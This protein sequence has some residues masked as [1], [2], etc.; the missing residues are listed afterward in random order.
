MQ[1]TSHPCK[2]EF[3]YHPSVRP[4]PIPC[5]PSHHPPL[6]SHVLLPK[7]ERPLL[8]P[9]F[10]CPLGSSHIGHR[11]PPNFVSLQNC[12]PPLE[13][14]TW[15]EL[16]HWSSPPMEEGSTALMTGAVV[17]PTREDSRALSCFWCSREGG[18]CVTQASARGAA[19]SGLLPRAGSRTRE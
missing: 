13:E 3:T 1:L 12:C 2:A 5:G 17:Q 8:I 9:P 14:K 15:A 18:T 11:G 7:W 4:S 19:P 6:G 10:P 16:R